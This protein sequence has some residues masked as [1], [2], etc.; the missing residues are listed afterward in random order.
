MIFT[1]IS[2]SSFSRLPL[3]PGGRWPR[4]AGGAGSAPPRALSRP[5]SGGRGRV[6]P[7]DELLVDRDV[8]LVDDYRGH[9]PHL[10]HGHPEELVVEDRLGEPDPLVDAADVDRRGQPA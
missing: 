6:R 3:P 9:V 5:A 1:L 2:C 8:E 10:V 7:L 4:T